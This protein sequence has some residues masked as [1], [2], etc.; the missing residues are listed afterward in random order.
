M[1][2]KEHLGLMRIKRVIFHDIPNHKKGAEG[3]LV[4]AT[5][6]TAVDVHRRN[7]L[8]AKITRVLDSKAA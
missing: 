2:K 7:M 6:E 5:V 3:H 4:L 1:L 8:Q